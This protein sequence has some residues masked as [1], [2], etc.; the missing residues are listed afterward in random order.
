MLKI[1][2]AKDQIPEEWVEHYERN[3]DGKYEPKIEGINSVSGLLAKRNELLEKVKE[4]PGLKTKLLEL[5]GQE[6]LTAGKIA[7]D[8]KEFDKIKAEHE[9]YVALGTLDDIKPKVEGF[10]DL[11]QKE[12]KRQK[13]DQYRAAAKVA[14][15][16]AAKFTQLALTDGIETVIKTVKENGKDIEKVF[17]KSTKDG[18]EVET[19]IMDYVQESPN[20]SPFADTLT[21]VTQSLGH[22]VILQGKST[23]ATP[24][25]DTEKEAAWASGAYSPF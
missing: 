13:E 9:S 1:Y 15:F 19:A 17:V 16:D 22:K 11:R 10:D 2:D 14:G 18:K 3:S 12:E 20:F 24:T 25:L 21:A 5:E 4:I 7:V 6:T 23:P 8:K